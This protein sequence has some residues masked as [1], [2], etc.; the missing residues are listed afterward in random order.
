MFYAVIRPVDST[1]C[2]LTA[3]QK[4]KAPF[5]YDLRAS[6]AVELRQSMPDDKLEH[7]STTTRLLND[8]S[9]CSRGTFDL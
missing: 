3:L 1:S 7:T 5:P 8:I 9:R 2:G 4:Q 6:Q